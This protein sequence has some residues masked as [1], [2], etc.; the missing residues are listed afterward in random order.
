M[1][2]LRFSV[3]QLCLTLFVLSA[4][5]HSQ[6]KYVPFQHRAAKPSAIES[7]FIDVGALEF[8]VA[9]DGRL[10]HDPAAG[11]YQGL[12]YPKGQRWGSVVY[13]A[14]PMVSGKIAGEVRSTT[15]YYA[16]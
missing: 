13:C 16:R 3:C 6:E 14:G 10:A 2:Y 4:P 12:Y 11:D 5:L 9:N 8:G 7:A 1:R 15:G